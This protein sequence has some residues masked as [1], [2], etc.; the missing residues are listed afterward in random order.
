[1]RNFLRILLAL[2]LWNGWRLI[3]FP[4]KYFLSILKPYPTFFKKPVVADSVSTKLAK[5]NNVLEILSALFSPPPVFLSLSNNTLNSLNP[6]NLV[7]MFSIWKLLKFMILLTANFISL[8]ALV[9]LLPPVFFLKLAAIFPN[10]LL[11]PNW[12]LMRDSILK[13]DNPAIPFILTGIFLNAV[14]P[15][16]FKDSLFLPLTET[17]VYRIPI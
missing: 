6:L 11:Y 8:P 5:F 12:L 17:F 7:S 15:T 4:S 16:F 14:R 1:M 13:T 3:L 9:K 2:L 10:F